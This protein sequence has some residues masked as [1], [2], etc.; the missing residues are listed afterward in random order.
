MAEYRNVRMETTVMAEWRE[1][2]PK[3]AVHVYE[4]GLVPDAKNAENQ[5]INLYPGVTYQTIRGFG[6]ALT[7]AS[8]AALAG[9]SEKNREKVIGTYFGPEGIGYS[10]GRIHVDSC[11]FSVSNYCAIENGED[12]AFAD[13]SLAEDEKYLLP[14]VRAVAKKAGQIPL[15]LSPWSPPAVFKDTG[16]RNGGGKLLPGYRKR[17]A[18]YIC[19]YIRA[20]RESGA[21]VAWFSL[22]NEPLAVQTW[23]S[24]TYTSAEEKEL[25]KEVHAAFLR[26]GLSDIGIYIWDHNKERVYERACE[27]LDEETRPMV[28]GIAYHWYSGDHFDTLRMAREAFPGIRLMHSE[29]CVG[30]PENREFGMDPVKAAFAYAKDICGDLKAG[31]DAWTDWNICLDAKGGPN[32]VGNFCDAPIICDGEADRVIYR[33]TFGAIRHFSAWMKPGAVLAG[34]SCYTGALQE[35]A[36]INP[37]G[38]AVMTVINEGTE[39][40]RA[41]LRTCGKCAALLFPAGSVSTV[42]VR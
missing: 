23:D 32:H 39:P 5:V 2:D 9:L 16:V 4:T 28:E 19:R 7:E 31:M 20:L 37:D 26:E 3:A 40:V 38:S 13:F 21:N 33:R 24:C 14:L 35:A 42:A 41:T 8:G 34:S 11:D 29:G 30:M 17:Y 12:D 27:I 22:Q 10:L 6:G 15:L 36:A 25:L 1:D 18:S